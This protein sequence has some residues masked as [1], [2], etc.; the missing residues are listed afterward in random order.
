MDVS[1]MII[2]WNTLKFLGLCAAD[3]TQAELICA[4]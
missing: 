4:A 1:V 2:N 3:E